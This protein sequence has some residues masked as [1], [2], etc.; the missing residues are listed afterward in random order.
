MHACELFQLAA[1]AASHS[2]LILG[3]ID[4]LS[5]RG[6]EQY[7]S[8]SKCRMLRWTRTLRQH[9]LPAANQESHCRSHWQLLA[10]T[11]E[12][13][14]LN[15][16]L[17]RVWTA[18]CGAHD[19]RLSCS[20]AEPIARSV[21]VGQ[22]EARNQVMKLILDQHGPHIE[23][24]EQL[25]SSAERWSDI[26]LGHFAGRIDVG[27]LAFNHDYVNSMA[28]EFRSQR[29]T[30]LSLDALLA[31]MQISLRRFGKIPSPNADLNQRLG[32]AIMVCMRSDLFDSTGILKSWWVERLNH[33]TGDT[34]GLVEDLLR[35]DNSLHDESP[36][37]PISH[38]RF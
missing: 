10:P 33:T 1:I 28:A 9:E 24:I 6:L 7:W 16:P 12:E 22:L 37:S 36:D 21:L 26:L 27:H 5:E 8:S 31:A 13:I 23:Q 35:L 4:R 29:A 18:V 15:E 19:E 34:Q 3:H 25:R 38:P 30:N 14:Y 20:I 17:A 11:I 32:S 2:E